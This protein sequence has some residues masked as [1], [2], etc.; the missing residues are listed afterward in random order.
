MGRADIL[1][2]NYVKNKK[3]FADAFNYYM[4]DGRKVIN[5]DKLYEVDTA[6]VAVPY[7]EDE[8]GVIVQP[9]QKMRDAVYSVMTDDNAVYMLLGIENQSESH[10]AMPVKNMLYDAMEYA[11]Q[12]QEA[13]RSHRKA[14]NYGSSAEFLSG[15]HKDDR[16]LPVVT[17]VIYWGDGE[18][19]GPKCL[20]DMLSVQDESVLRFV[21]NYSINLIIPDEMTDEEMEKFSSDLGKALMY[22]KNMRSPA[23]LSKMIVDERYKT[24]DVETGILLSELMNFKYTVPKNEEAMDMCYAIEYLV[25]EAAEKASILTTIENFRE[26]GVDDKMIEEKIMSK[27]NLSQEKA[28]EYMLG[29]SA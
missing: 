12:V 1:T 5:P 25:N 4:Y 3:V 21:S 20:Y 7:G 14:E 13:A 16:L 28:K 19:L 15:F 24:I 11:A 29:K 18:W 22:I 6:E 17:L 9:V 10:Y 2:K 23:E 26:F 27:F 8:A